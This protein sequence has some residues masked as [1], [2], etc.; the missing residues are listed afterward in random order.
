MPRD[1]HIRQRRPTIRPM[2][3]PR[4]RAARLTW[5]KRHL[6]FRRQ[7]WINIMFPDE[8]RRERERCADTRAMQHRPFGEGSA[9]VLGGITKRGRTLLV[10]VAGHLTGTRYRGEIARRYVILFIQPQGNNVTFQ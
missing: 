2:L 3:L 1:R 4:N 9:M 6:R 5:L 10:I 8:Y 7:D